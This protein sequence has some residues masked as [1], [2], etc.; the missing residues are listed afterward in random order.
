MG[1]SLRKLLPGGAEI[2]LWRIAESE[3]KLR[4][5]LSGHNHA[6]PDTR[7]EALRRERLAVLALVDCLFDGLYSLG[8]LDSGRPYLYI[9]GGG[10]SKD[11][12]AS[13][14]CTEIPRISVSHTDGWAAVAVSPQSEVGI[15]IESEDRSFAAVERK[16]LSD[17]EIGWLCDDC[18]RN[19]QLG[20][21]WCAKEAV[22]KRMGI[23]V[24]DFSADME[25]ERFDLREEGELSAIYGNER[26]IRLEYMMYSGHIVVWTVE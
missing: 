10:A 11:A 15:D 21:V 22:Y 25:I 14:V 8:H 18:R 6:I 26:R 2:A 19:L 4:R 17:N 20:V 16:A 9:Y 12:D 5:L 3:E 7:S 1:L 23:E 13:P 24:V